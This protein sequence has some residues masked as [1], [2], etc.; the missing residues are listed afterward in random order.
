MT[1]RQLQDQRKLAAMILLAAAL[2]GCPGPRQPGP[3]T[4]T[5]ATHTVVPAP[6]SI[7]ASQSEPFRLDST[8]AIVTTNVAEVARTGEM[9]AALLRPAT[10][11]P[12]PV[13]GDT[14]RVGAIA[15]RLNTNATGEAYEIT[16]TRDSIRIS[17]T[18]PGIFRGVQTLRQLMPASVESDM[19]VSGQWTVP[20]VTVSDQPRF[21]WRGSMLDVS[22]HF[23]TVDE[24]KQFIDLLA[25]Y[26]LNVLHLH[27]ADDQGWR[28]EIKS[29][30]RLASLGGVTQVGGGPGGFYTQAEY[31]DIVRYAQDRYISIVPEIDMP[32]HTNAALV[33]HPELSCSRIPPALYTRTEVGWSAFCPN[34]EETY[35]LI[36]D[37]IRELAAL[38]PGRYIHIGGDEVEVLSHADYIKFVER[39]Q[40]IVAR[41]GKEMVGWEEIGKARLRPTTLAQLWKSDSAVLALRSGAKLI[42]SPSR[43][44][45]LDMKYT[46]H[47]EL[48]LTWAAIIEVSDV[49]N[50]DPAT[51]QPGVTESNIVGVEGPIWS[52]TLRNITAVQYLAMPRLPA[53]AEVGWTPQS[54]RSWEDFRVRI[55]AHAPRWNYLGVNYYRS[56][57]V[58]W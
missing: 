17:G 18:A 24:V 39:V 54:A 16:V 29:R 42:M 21:A 50:W 40:E 41:H 33:A 56:P 1:E 27:L 45:Y 11:F 7:R 34:K 13:V 14:T 43:K 49:Y 58:P 38:T 53:L 48:G 23:F 9:L 12:I 55:A 8:S 35:A 5:R 10:G 51:Y 22:R 3:A 25:L 31:S 30:P 32:G 6:V 57:Q 15:L 47:T 4:P 36:D 20:A 2:L 52:E 28:I 19:Q 46:Q 44:A 37:V 26:K